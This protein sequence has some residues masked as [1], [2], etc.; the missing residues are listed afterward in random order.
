MIYRDRAAPTENGLL[1]TVDAQTIS[2]S[3]IMHP[4]PIVSC[5]RLTLLVV[6]AVLWFA[7]VS[8]ACNPTGNDPYRCWERCAVDPKS[9]LCVAA[10]K[11]WTTMQNCPAP[12]ADELRD[13]LPYSYPCTCFVNPN[14]DPVYDDFD[15]SSKVVAKG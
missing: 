7:A 6:V 5:R 4:V 1:Q 10:C 8:R 14:D 15:N 11:R 13:D 12:A 2:L 3:T 9:P